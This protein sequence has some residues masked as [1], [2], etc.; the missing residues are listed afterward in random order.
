[1][2]QLNTKSMNQLPIRLQQASDEIKVLLEKH[3]LAGVAVLHCPEM[4]GPGKINVITCLGPTYSA[5][6]VK[7]GRLV[8]RASAP[9][10]IIE[11]MRPAEEVNRERAAD[12]VNM[13]FNLRLKTA[14][15]TQSLLQAELVVRQRFKMPLPPD[16]KP[17]VNGKKPGGHHG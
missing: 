7:D 11:G 3:N 4:E 9:P 8:M 2:N 6:E 16:V 1:M 12:T 15:V 5:V 17:A 14:Q 10:L 13:L